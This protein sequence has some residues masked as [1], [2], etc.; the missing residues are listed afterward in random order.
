MNQL[1]ENDNFYRR[2]VSFE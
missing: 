1:I 2:K